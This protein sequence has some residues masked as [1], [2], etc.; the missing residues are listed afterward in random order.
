MKLAC[1]KAIAELAEAEQNDEVALAYA[2]Q[3]LTFGP[4]YIIPK[5]FDPRLIVKIA[6]AVAQAAA[7]SGVARRP[8]ED[9]EAYRQKLMT[10]VYHTGQLM[11]RSEEHPSE[12]QS[13][14]RPSYAVFS[15]TKTQTNSPA[16]HT[17]LTTSN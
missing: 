10:L 6:P 7:L 8:I 11:R 15:S 16:L 13:L 14:M 5:P 12:L 2:G 17:T 4:D 3:E 9:L 1:V